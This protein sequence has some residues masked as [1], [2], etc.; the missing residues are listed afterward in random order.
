M[1]LIYCACGCGQ[2]REEL[3]K[4]GRKR[5]YI[6]KHC[7][8]KNIPQSS[9]TKE[10]NRKS[11]LGKE[12]WNKNLKGIHLSPQSEFKLGQLSGKNHWN[13]KGGISREYKTSYYS[14]KYKAWRKAVF[15][16]DDFTCRECGKMGYITAHHIKSF[17]QYPELRFDLNNGITL[18]EKCHSKTD[19][20]KGRNLKNKR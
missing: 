12:T 15:I 1:S 7:W 10:K 3:D 2:Q 4:R 20:Y 5:K 19:N 18:C 16:R 9:S 13:W 14:T 8:N 6:Y 17:A 11:H